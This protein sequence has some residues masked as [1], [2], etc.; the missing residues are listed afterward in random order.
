MEVWIGR[1]HE[2]DFR[3]VDNTSLVL[4][5]S[6]HFMII[7]LAIDIHLDMQKLNYNIHKPCLFLNSGV[8]IAIDLTSIHS[9]KQKS[10]ENL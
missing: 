7:H 9:L 4:D 6:D 3:G 1:E 10:N 8:P 2:A 5:T